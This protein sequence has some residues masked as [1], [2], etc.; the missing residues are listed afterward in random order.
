MRSTYLYMLL[1][2]LFILPIDKTAAQKTASTPAL[3]ADME[4]ASLLMPWDDAGKHIKENIFV[5]AIVNKNTCYV[6]EPLLVTYKLFTRLQ[7]HSKVVDAPT[8]TGCSV[9]EMTTN[10]LK[11]EKEIVGGKLYKTF[12]I[13]KVQLVPL[14]EGI[15]SLGEV[16]VDNEVIL[17]QGTNGSY[18]AIKKQVHLANSAVAIQVKPLPPNTTTD[19]STGVVGNFF[20]TG[21]LNRTIDTANDNNAIELTITGS[22]NFMNMSCPLVQWPAGIQ[23]YEPKVSEILDKLAFPV[24]GEKKFI[25]PFTCKHQ[26]EFIIPAIS[27]TYFDADAGKYATAGIDYI[28]LKVLPAVPLIDPDKLS[29]GIADLKYL[30]IVPGIAAI[31]GMVMMY[32]STR[33]KKINTEYK[34]NAISEKNNVSEESKALYA[35]RLAALQLTINNSSFYIDAKELAFDIIEDITAD[36]DIKSLEK[37]LALCNEALYAYK[38]V[39]KEQIIIALRY[40]IEAL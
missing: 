17:Y 25:I 32:Y 40:G 36:D 34:P 18:N 15:L 9:I 19:S 21:K 10:N 38:E 33:K 31:V 16:S 22:G 8:F 35:E 20:M 28:H 23:A 30:W 1:G 24:L 3:E 4:R 13:R 2:L 14:Q 27:F 12:I 5:R 37:V 26:G 11:E 7:S 39:D 29:I 6:G